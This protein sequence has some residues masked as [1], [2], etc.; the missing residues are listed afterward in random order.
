MKGGIEPCPFMS[1]SC[2]NVRHGGL[3]TACQ[4]HFLRTIREHPDLLQRQQYACSLFEHY[5]EVCELHQNISLQMAEN[6]NNNENF[7]RFNSDSFSPK[8]V[9]L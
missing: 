3:K 7:S 9:N 4:S 5:Q 6:I 8:E 2:D 1:F